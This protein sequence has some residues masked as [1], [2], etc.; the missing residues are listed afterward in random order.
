MNRS[1]NS[2]QLYNCTYIYFFLIL[3]SAS[4]IANL[5]NIRHDHFYA[6]ISRT[7]ERKPN[8]HSVRTGL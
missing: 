5:R 6:D 3:S 2:I 7:L 1:E 8:H 4:D